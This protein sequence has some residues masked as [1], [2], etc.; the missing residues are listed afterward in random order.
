M[1]GYGLTL[2]IKV[3]PHMII[4]RHSSGSYPL[5]PCARAAVHPCGCSAMCSR[6]RLSNRRDLLSLPAPLTAENWGAPGVRPGADLCRCP[7]GR[8]QSSGHLSFESKGFI[9]LI[10]HTPV[11]LCVTFQGGTKSKCLCN[12]IRVPEPL[13]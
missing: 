7:L 13:F 9:V 6:A 5:T 3:L 11:V 12:A 10:L 1:W 4:A 2:E 8:P